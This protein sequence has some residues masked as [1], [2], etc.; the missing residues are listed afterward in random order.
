M[1]V[2]TVEPYRFDLMW[3]EA[4]S[5]LQLNGTYVIVWLCML[6]CKKLSNKL[7]LIL[8][9]R[10]AKEHLHAEYALCMSSISDPGGPMV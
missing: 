6:S 10:I 4:A 3:P 2:L 7:E 8:A 5:L 9:N 1:I